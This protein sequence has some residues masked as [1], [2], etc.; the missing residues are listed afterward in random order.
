MITTNGREAGHPIDPLFLQRW[1]PRAFTGEEIA[2][3]DLLTMI[4]AARWAASSYNSQPW[5]F[6]YARRGTPPWEAFLG[7]LNPFNA[8]WAK[9]AAALVV[10]VSNSVMR[11]PGAD[12]DV[13]SH[14]HSLDAGAA[15][16]NF[17]LQATRMGWQV[18]GMVGFD[19]ERAF[20][21]LNVPLGYRV[22]AVYAVGRPGDPATLPEALRGREVPSPRR[23]LA[24]IAL[25]GGFPA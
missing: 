1:S 6:L 14:S 24:E 2:P 9:D 23:P 4:E 8:G 22:E 25:E 13:P 20:A 3:E 11:P 15:S 7:L 17:A 12:K 19:K 10:L 18:H 21:E 5:R 16:G